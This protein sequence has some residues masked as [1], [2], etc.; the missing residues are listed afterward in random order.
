MEAQRLGLVNGQTLS[1]NPLLRTCLDHLR[2][3]AAVVVVIGHSRNQLWDPFRKLDDPSLAMKGVYFITNFHFEAVIVFFCLSGLLVG[4]SG[5]ARIAEGAFDIRRYAADR[6]SR[7]VPPYLTAFAVTLAVF[8]AVAA[9]IP[10]AAC[11]SISWSTVLV[12]LTFMQRVGEPAICNNVALWSLSNET[13][14]Y[15]AFGLFA[16]V[17]MGRRVLP[18]LVLI[19]IVAVFLV[20]QDFKKGYVVIYA[21]MWWAGVLVWVRRT[22]RMPLTLG[23]AAFA[24]ALILSRTHVIDDLFWLR[25]G[26][27]ALG[28]AA[29]LCAVSDL[30]AGRAASHTRLAT[31]FR[32][33]GRVLADMSYSLY[34]FHMPV[35][36]VIWN[37][38]EHTAVTK[39]PGDPTTPQA[40][41]LLLSRCRR[42]GRSRCAWIRSRGTS[43]G[44]HPAMSL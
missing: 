16:L 38:A 20:F 12:H 2:W 1:D 37:V 25:D 4:G 44:R 23:A 41:V 29:F 36:W 32:R 19:T 8:F 13:W 31:A 33:I 40:W 7:I 35:V 24:A 11:Q 28:T 10:E 17:I 26:L 43:Y 39:I 18:V 42:L 30:G 6:I 22:W 3:V 5:L 34:L 15:V 14:Y 9:V 27:I 21:F